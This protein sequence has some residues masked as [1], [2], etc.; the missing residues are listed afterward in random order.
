MSFPL[1]APPPIVSV[2]IGVEPIVLVGLFK[3][4]NVSSRV[5]ELTTSP[6]T[7]KSMFISLHSFFSPI[8]SIVS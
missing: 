8:I 5:A 7:I 2:P 1:H 6:S 4:T 3:S